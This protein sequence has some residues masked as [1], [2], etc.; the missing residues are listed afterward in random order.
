[1][2][3]TFP[4][5]TGFTPPSGFDVTQISQIGIQVGINAGP[6]GGVFPTPTPLTFHIDSV[7]A[8]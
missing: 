7:V 8:Q 4:F 1:M 5:G 2:T 6:D 3:L